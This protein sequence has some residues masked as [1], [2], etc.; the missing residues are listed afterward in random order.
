MIDPQV[1]ANAW[2]KNLESGSNLVVVDSSN[3]LHQHQT[4]LENALQLGY[5]C[6][7]ENLNES[8]DPIIYKLLEQKVTRTGSQ[9]HIKLGDRVIEVNHDFRLYLTTKLSNPHYSPEVCLIVNMLNFSVTLEGL[10]EQLMNIIVKIDEPVKEEQRIRNIQEIFLNKIRISETSDIILELLS[11]AV[12]ELLE[13]EKLVLSLENSKST[14]L[15]I[16]GRIKRL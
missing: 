2:I 13:D 3:S 6:L 4:Q 1:Q 15:E 5:P 12:G 16:D 8:I 14:A 9:N 7:V 11:T 10:T